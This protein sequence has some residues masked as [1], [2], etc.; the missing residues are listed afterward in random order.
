MYAIYGNI[1]HQY[2]PFMLAYIPYMDPMGTVANV[3]F[4]PV[5]CFS[6]LNLC[7][8]EH[9]FDMFWIYYSKLCSDL[10]IFKDRQNLLPMTTQR[11]WN[12]KGTVQALAKHKHAALSMRHWGIVWPKSIGATWQIPIGLLWNTCLRASSPWRPC[13]V[14]DAAGP[15]DW[16]RSD[17]QGI[18]HL[19]ENGFEDTVSERK[20]RDVVIRGAYMVRRDGRV[21][22][23]YQHQTTIKLS[24]NLWKMGRGQNLIIFRSWLWFI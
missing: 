4:F 20:T 11:P 16:M 22:S 7:K 2:T 15:F 1:Y 19:V 14:G 10:Q 21:I 6:L 3:S 23:V 12:M 17:C 18:T 9:S 5:F 8:S 13:T 24:M